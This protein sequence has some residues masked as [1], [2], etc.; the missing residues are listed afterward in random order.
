MNAFDM[1]SVVRMYT[2]VPA[3]G[4]IRA[5]QGHR[6]EA[7]WFSA[8]YGEVEVCIIPVLDWE[9]PFGVGEPYTYVLS[10]ANPQVLHIPGGYLNGF[11]SLTPNSILQV[12]S[13]ASLE[14]SSQDDYR[15]S[16]EEIP[17]PTPQ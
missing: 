2:I 12:Y 15:V 1:K 11:R 17:W 9:V 10:S 5:W 3:M 6:V 4:V 7:K 14:A 13:D 16:L 8:L